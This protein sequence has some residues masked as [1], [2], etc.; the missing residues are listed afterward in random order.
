ALIR[1]TGR[2]QAQGGRV[3]ARAATTADVARAAIQLGGSI[4]AGGIARTA[5]G[6]R[7]GEP[8]ATAETNARAYR[9][10]PGS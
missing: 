6:V 9:S 4:E 10:Q 5:G 8:P 2:I 3:E 1:Q 7:F